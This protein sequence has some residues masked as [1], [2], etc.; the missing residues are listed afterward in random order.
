MREV[1]WLLDRL[2]PAAILNY[3]QAALIEHMHKHPRMSYTIESHRRSHNVT[4]QTARTDLLKLV[5][6]GLMQYA[7]RSRAFI[8][9]QAVDFDERLRGLAR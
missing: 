7:K 2:A 3:R 4:Y 5:E 1:Q 6:I 9:T 8:F